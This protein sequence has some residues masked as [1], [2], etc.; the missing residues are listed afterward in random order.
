MF[1]Y[2]VLAWGGD[3]FA[4]LLL[5]AC[6]AQMW[7]NKTNVVVMCFLTC[8]C[9]P[10]VIPRRSCDQRQWL[11]WCSGGAEGCGGE[12]VLE[13]K[14]NSLK[15]PKS[16]STASCSRTWCVLY[17]AWSNSIIGHVNSPFF[18]KDN[19]A[20]TAVGWRSENPQNCDSNL[21]L[22]PRRH[23]PGGSKP[24]LNSVQR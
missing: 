20:N 9:G 21:F 8:G 1:C 3:V 18:F 23:C 19:K 15:P 22:I 2:L 12:D 6:W 13:I 16:V 5:L 14:I 4:L 17:L 11:V 7:A 24:L 10:G